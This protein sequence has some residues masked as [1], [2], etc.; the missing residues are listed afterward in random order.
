LNNTYISKKDNIIEALNEIDSFITRME[1]F[2][3]RHPRYN[4]RIKIDKN[5]NAKSINKW[6]IELNVYKNE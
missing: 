2:M 6:V 5:E 1:D 3:Q 4:Y